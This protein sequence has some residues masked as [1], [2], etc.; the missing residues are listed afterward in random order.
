[1]LSGTGIAHL[2]VILPPPPL[3][4]LSFGASRS[5][6]DCF[7]MESFGFF[8][9]ALVAPAAFFMSNLRNDPRV[10]DNSIPEAYG[11]ALNGTSQETRFR[12][13]AEW[14]TLRRV[15]RPECWTETKVWWSRLPGNKTSL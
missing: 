14:P 7:L 15:P 13:A 3:T 8:L 1:M 12:S 4:P 9:P 6:T 5:L 2:W 11:A 10:G